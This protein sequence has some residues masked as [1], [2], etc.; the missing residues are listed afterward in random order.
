MTDKLEFT[1]E[2]FTPECEREIWYEHL[3]RY[4]FARQLVA[5]KSVLDAACGEGYGSALL[6]STAAS[7]V[8]LDLSTQTIDH[9]RKR[10]AGLSGL[11]FE[12]G[13]CTRLPF[14]D[15]QFGSIVSFETLEHLREQQAM[16]AEFRRVLKEEGFLIISSPDKKT[17]SDDLSYENP[18]HV[19]ELYFDEFKALLEEQFPATR[20]LGQKLIFQ[21]A[22]WD[23]AARGAAQLDSHCESGQII[24]SDTPGY[25]PLYH[26]ALCAAHQDCL[27]D[28]DQA[29]WLFGDEQESVYQHYY[30]EIRK[31]MAA[32]GLLEE[33]DQQI[34]RLKGQLEFLQSSKFRGLL[35]WLKNLLKS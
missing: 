4:V 2:R 1:G 35:T 30:H 19:R 11:S 29:L 12:T 14:E 8:G 20:F 24:T 18:H 6:A 34:G 22:I 31:N 21:S 3:H 5:G 25:A 26:I 17:Y 33:K 16:L 7:V 13:D 27:P 10:Y 15:R 32:G 28:T 23:P 9:A